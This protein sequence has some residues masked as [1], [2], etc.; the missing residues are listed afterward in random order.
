MLSSHKESYYGRLFIDFQN[1]IVRKECKNT[2]EGI[3]PNAALLRIRKIH[4][5]Q[6]IVTTTD[7][8]VSILRKIPSRNSP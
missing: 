1:I 3:R 7:I 8:D 4:K 5:I 6:N 2:F